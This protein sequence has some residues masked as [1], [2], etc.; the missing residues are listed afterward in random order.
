M[1]A[2]K[3]KLDLFNYHKYENSR[4]AYWFKLGNS[5]L[6]RRNPPVL[7]RLEERKIPLK[8]TTGSLSPCGKNVKIA[9]NAR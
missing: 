9:T 4:V 6:A 1:V 7:L 8:H 5:E 3:H 2:K